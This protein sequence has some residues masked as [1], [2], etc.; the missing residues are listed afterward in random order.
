MSGYSCV[1]DE[2]KLNFDNK[3][4]SIID[5]TKMKVIYN[6]ISKVNYVIDKLEGVN[7]VFIIF[8]LSDIRKLIFDFDNIYFTGIYVNNKNEKEYALIYEK[9]IIITQNLTKDKI[10]NYISL[11]NIENQSD[12]E[13]LLY[14]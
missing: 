4:I 2:L 6:G 8:T 9:Y 14:N 12:V 3:N 1:L 10:K 11:Q 13:D 5:K 7:K